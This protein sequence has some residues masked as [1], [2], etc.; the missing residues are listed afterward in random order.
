[1][2]FAACVFGCILAACLSQSS[3]A[4][5]VVSPKNVQGTPPWWVAGEFGAGQITLNT[6]QQK[7]GGNTTFAMG[8]AGGYQPTDWMRV[9]LHVNGWLLQAFNLYDPTIGESVSNVGA[10]VDVLPVRKAGLFARGGFGLGTYTN[11]RPP[12]TNGNGPAWE[13]GGGFEIPVRGAIRLAPTVEYSAGSLGKGSGIFP[14]QTGLNYSVLEFKL[15]VIGKFG[16]R[17]R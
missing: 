2:K 12:G 9:G 4:Q 13:A 15:A 6:D 11:D 8:F 10:V 14:L 17:R 1:M 7:G 16:H 3:V 5:P